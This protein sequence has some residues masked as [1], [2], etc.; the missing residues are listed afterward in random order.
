[1]TVFF[2]VQ[3]VARYDAEFCP[4]NRII[5]HRPSDSHASFLVPQPNPR[6][7]W[8]VFEVMVDGQEPPDRTESSVFS[9]RYRAD[10]VDY[11]TAY[12]LA[13]ALSGMDPKGVLQLEFIYRTSPDD[14]TIYH[15]EEWR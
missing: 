2:E 9:R 6:R 12:A 13:L 10:C 1:M 7:E 11:A 4:T 15:Q 14:L 8:R 3:R 5:A